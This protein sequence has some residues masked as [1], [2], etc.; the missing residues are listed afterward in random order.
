MSPKKLLPLVFCFLAMISCVDNLDFSQI[1][2]YNAT[3]EYTSSITYFT[4]LAKQFFNQAGVQQSERIDVTD[5]RIFD[6]SY[7]RNNLVKVDF[8]V[9]IKNEFD[10]SFTIQIDFLDD[11]NLVTYSFLKPLIITANKLDYTNP[12]EEILI[13]NHLIFLNTTRIKIFVTDNSTAPLNSK[14]TSELEFKSSVKI[15]IDTGV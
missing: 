5:F 12:T 8:N 15:Y 1:E 6:N 7:I 4:I 3:P 13:S 2:D 14:D 11:N 10:R 9:E